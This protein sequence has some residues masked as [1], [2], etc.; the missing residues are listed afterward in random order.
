[1]EPPASLSLESLRRA[2]ERI[3]PHVRVTAVRQAPELGLWVKC[4]N[5]QFTGSFKLRGALNK[6]LGLPVSSRREAL[7][8]ASAGNH[9]LGVAWAARLRQVTATIVVPQGAVQAKVDAIRELG[10]HVLVAE[11]GYAQAEEQGKQL[12]QDTGAVWI[13]PYN[14]LEVIAGQGTVGLEV[15]EQLE[16]ASEDGEGWQVSVPVGGGGLVCGV[17]AA[18]KR[19]SPRVRLIGVQAANSPYLHA[20]FHGA[21]MNRVVERPTLADGLAGAVEA[22]AVTL[23]MV[24][25]LV[26]DC[27]LVDE[28]AIEDAIRWADQRLGEVIEP[29][30]AAALAACLGQPGT[31]RRLVILSGGNIAPSLLARVRGEGIRDA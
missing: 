21:D 26:D 20:C 15:A 9:G 18:L 2:G 11:G 14:D 12:A 31:G 25:A 23:E 7:V 8:A 5:R 17:A 28:P 24:R 6:I 29:S 27:V 1:M 4:E 22:E 13:S 30:A 3:R 10:A 16:L 19:L